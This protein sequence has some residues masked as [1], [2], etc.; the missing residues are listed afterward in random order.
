MIQGFFKYK[1]AEFTMDRGPDG[2]YKLVRG[3]M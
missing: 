3:H 1:K 2:V